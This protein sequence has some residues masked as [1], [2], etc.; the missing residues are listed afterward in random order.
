MCT[1]GLQFFYR[2]DAFKII[3]TNV[4]RVHGKGKKKRKEKMAV[5]RKT[6][7]NDMIW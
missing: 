7:F 1:H 4:H 2:T 3:I 6:N 5:I